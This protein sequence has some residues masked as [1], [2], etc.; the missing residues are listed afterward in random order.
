MLL[1]FEVSLFLVAH[2]IL[3]N[4]LILYS[5]FTGSNITAMHLNSTYSI[6]Q[7]A[8]NYR[9]PQFLRIY[10]ETKVKINRKTDQ[11][12]SLNILPK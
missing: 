8:K 4:V 12:P 3:T 10:F 7:C 5:G 9:A 1:Q 11:T 6:V 2:G